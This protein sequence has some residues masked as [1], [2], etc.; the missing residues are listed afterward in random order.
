[1]FSL[2][3]IVKPEITPLF[4][5]VYVSVSLVSV[6]NLPN[7]VDVGSINHKML[8]FL[9]SKTDNVIRFIP[10]IVC[11]W[12]FLCSISN[13]HSLPLPGSESPTQ[14]ESGTSLIYRIQQ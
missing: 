3:S 12:Y 6:L 11:S 14:M 1:M 2:L 4:G 8:S 9:G 5:N 13:S 7:M 10:L